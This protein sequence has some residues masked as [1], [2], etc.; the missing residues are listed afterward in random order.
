MK[1]IFLDFDGVLNSEKYLHSCGQFGVVLDPSRLILLEQIVKATG[2]QIV[3]SSSWREHWGQTLSACDETGITINKIFNEHGLKVFDKTPKLGTRR[4]QEIAA[5]ALVLYAVKIILYA[6]NNSIGFFGYYGIFFCVIVVGSV[7]HKTV[8]SKHGRAK[9][10]AGYIII[11]A[12]NIPIFAVN[13]A[14]IIGAGVYIVGRR[15][16]EG[17]KMERPE[18]VKRRG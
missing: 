10:H 11:V 14:Q 1:I 9:G 3:L 12:G 18:A 16:R 15:T 7:C 2:A 4:E 13:T 8:F 5:C 17:R 6:G